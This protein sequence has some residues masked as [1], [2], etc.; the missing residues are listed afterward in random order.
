MNSDYFIKFAG[1]TNFDTIEW[2][3]TAEIGGFAYG[4]LGS[5]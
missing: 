5:S 3:G 2:G 4:I 1:D